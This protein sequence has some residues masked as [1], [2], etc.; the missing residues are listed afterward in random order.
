MQPSGSIMM[1]LID[2]YK[3]MINTRTSLEILQ[4]N[5][6]K[7]IEEFFIE[8]ELK[9]V[10]V[11]LYKKYIRIVTNYTMMEYEIIEMI[12]DKYPDWEVR[13]LNN[14]GTIA[15]LLCLQQ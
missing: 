10:N 8:N 12:H 13:V 1:S 4:D 3:T 6:I 9:A 11:Q 14:N 5:I 2:N 7:E 15:I